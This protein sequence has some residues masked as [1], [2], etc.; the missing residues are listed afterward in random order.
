MSVSE[1]AVV[2][3]RSVASFH[4]C[5]E[6]RFVFPLLAL[7]LLEARLHL[8]SSFSASSVI[9]YRTYLGSHIR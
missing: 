2:W 7:L 1:A 3:S 5:S 4:G 6:H 8:L 9:T